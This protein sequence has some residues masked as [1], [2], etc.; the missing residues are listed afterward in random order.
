[1]LPISNKTKL[2]EKFNITQDIV[3]KKSEEDEIEIIEEPEK[4]LEL[5]EE[6]LDTKEN[7]EEEEVKVNSDNDK[8]ENKIPTTFETDKEKLKKHNN[9]EAIIIILKKSETSY[10]PFI[11]VL[12]EKKTTDGVEEMIFIKSKIN[13][14][15][16]D[17]QISKLISDEFNYDFINMKNQLS[18]I[19]FKD[20]S[21]PT[22]IY[23]LTLEEEIDVTL[24]KRNNR[25]WWSLPYELVNTLHVCNFAINYDVTKFF[26]DHVELLYL[27]DEN[28]K[29]LELPIVLYFGN[30]QNNINYVALFGVKRTTNNVGMAGPL[31]Y[32]SDYKQAIHYGGWGSYENT[33]TNNEKIDKGG[34]V[35]FAVFTKKLF[36]FIYH[37]DNKDDD[38]SVAKELL[39]A[40]SDTEYI[41]KTIKYR[42]HDANWS[43]M[44]DTVYIG[45]ITDKE[46]NEQI[47][48]H[49]LFGI[50]NMKQQI[51]LTYHHLDL[52]KFP[53]QFDESRND[54]YIL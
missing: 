46:T 20:A 12:L 22:L 23:N 42:D 28:N 44:A 2:L 15:S 14:E 43:D 40:H 18:F 21:T 37:P 5:A 25:Y 19:G 45:P 32:F 48:K 8:I 47:T 16:I 9:N 6:V 36:S 30:H 26:L 38:S 7:N 33:E 27:Y 52:D 29:Q 4:S 31:Y 17:E 39:T 54:Y 3:V 50:K 35:R 49:P 1:M 13:V 11:S 41:R 51:P 24:I 34:I 10:L 53:Y